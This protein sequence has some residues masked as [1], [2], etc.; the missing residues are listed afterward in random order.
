MLDGCSEAQYMPSGY[1]ALN[2]QLGGLE[3]LKSR[4]DRLLDLFSVVSTS[5]PRSCLI[6]S[7]LLGLRPNEILNLVKFDL[8][9]L[10]QVF[11]P[12]H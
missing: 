5:N 7:Q 11:A 1:R 9:Y 2:L 3:F 4:P 8:N 10:F 12:P 6:P